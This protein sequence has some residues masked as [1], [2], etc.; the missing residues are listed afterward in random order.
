MK[1]LCGLVIGAWGFRSAAQTADPLAIANAA[2]RRNLLALMDGELA[3]LVEAE[4]L[5]PKAAEHLEQLKPGTFCLHKSWGFGRV[6]E[7]NLLL[8]QIVIDFSGKKGHPMQLQYA[9]D[10]LAAIPPEHF[11]ARK[12]T[13]REGT[14]KL[15][16]E[17][18]SALVKNILE[19]LGGKATPQQISEWMVGDMFTE[20]EW[21][22]WWDSTK[23]AL[24]KDG[25]FFIPTKKNEPVELRAAPVAQ[26]DEL[27]AEFNRAR[28]PKEQTAAM[29]QII[30][31][32][33]E[34]PNPGAQLQPVIV[35]LEQAAVRN[36]KL[37][38]ALSFELV[39]GRDELLEKVPELKPTNLSLSLAKLIT[40]EESR[41]SSILPKLPAAK[42]RRVVQAMPAALGDRFLRRTWDLMRGSHGRVIPQ[43]A[44]LFTESGRQAELHEFLDR[45]IREHSATTE[46]LIWLCKDRK[47]WPGLVT[48][49]LMTAILGAIEREQ[50]NETSR[51]GRLRDLLIDDRELI[52]D[53]FKNAEI[54]IARDAMRRL[55]LT[56]AIDEL[57]KRSLFARIVKLY[58]ELEPMITGAQP[59]EKAVPLVVS[60]TSL[61]K[62]R[63]EY[64]DLIKKKI[65]E[66]TKEIALARSYG[67]LS[68]NFEFKA[69]KQMQAVLMRRKSELEHMLHSARGT[70]FENADTSR[71]SI[72]TI[73]RLRNTESGDEESYTILGAWDGDPDRHIISYQTAIGQALLGHQAGDTVTIGADLGAS[74]QVEIIAIEP[75]PVDAPPANLELVEAEALAE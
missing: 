45:S 66:N 69:A 23:K 60:W 1:L 68:E 5:T 39:L 71:V 13:D 18:P 52:A 62:R 41:L 42:E 19:S 59:E 70:S 53:M 34:F 58:P 75:A 30:K 73:V 65:P 2:V 50:H 20:A 74:H 28:Q 63:A 46:M 49:D 51:G 10:N 43:L 17:D 72:G 7:W 48:P 9:A 47:D 29:E 15:A 35:A 32:Y 27:L 6:A 11:L 57:T 61:E 21:K 22:R 14:K 64:E 12:A 54:G 36:Q 33:H 3:K 56:P 31:L 40:D 24:K 37:H 55:L 8:N 25:H 38:P 16:K 4:K 44:R 67:D 26:S